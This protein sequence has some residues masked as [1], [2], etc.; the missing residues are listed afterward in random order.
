[1]ADVLITD[2]D[3]VEKTV[4]D[5]GLVR[6]VTVQENDDLRVE[7]TEYR[8]PASD[9]IVHRSVHAQMKRWPGA[10]GSLQGSFS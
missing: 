7:A 4:D 1:M 6:T 3:G 9:V 10:L 5:A 8:W 2:L